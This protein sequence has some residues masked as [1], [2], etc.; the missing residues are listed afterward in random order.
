[1]EKNPNCPKVIADTMRLYIP[2]VH[3]YLTAFVDNVS[4]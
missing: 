4:K 3:K 2:Q 1:L